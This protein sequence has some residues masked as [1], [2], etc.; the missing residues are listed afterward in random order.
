[1][2]KSNLCMGAL[3][4]GMC[5]LLVMPLSPAFGENS[6]DTFHLSPKVVADFIH[7]VIQADRTLYTTHIVERLEGH[8]VVTA[9]EYW[10]QQ[11][12]LPLPAQMLM[13]SGLQVKQEGTGLQFR[14]ASLYPIYEKNGPTTDFEKVGLE[15]VAKDPSQ[16]YTGVIQRGDRNFFKAIYADKAVSPACVNCHNGHILSSKHDYQL[17]DVMGGIVIS[18]PLN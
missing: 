8:K 12:A 15:A 16:P 2:F 10:K 9:Q 17:G 3:V 1:M 5:S 13:L 18:F 11:K 7:S 14:L 6:Q 4:W